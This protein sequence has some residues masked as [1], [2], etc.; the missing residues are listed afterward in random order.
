MTAKRWPLLVLAIVLMLPI[1]T[2]CSPTTREDRPTTDT[3]TCLRTIAPA[4]GT[5]TGIFVEPDDTRAPI[6]NELDHARC[7]I[8]VAVYLLT[9]AEVIAALEAAASRG[10]RV[11]LILEHYPYGGGG[12]QDDLADRLRSEGIDVQWSDNQFRFTHAKYIVVDRQVALILNQNLT[13]SSFT[14]NREFGAVTTDPEAVMGAQLIFDRDWER[15]RQPVAAPPLI[16]SPSDSR[17]RYEKIIGEARVSIDLYAEVIQDPEIIEA[18]EDAV[19]RGVRVRLIL[20]PS[21]GA[22]DIA[23]VAGLRSRGVD[24]RA[25]TRLYIHAKLMIVDGTTAIVG[26]QNFT[27]TSLDANREL[28]LIVQDPLAVAR[29]REIFTTDWDAARQGQVRNASRDSMIAFR[30]LV[31]SE[32]AA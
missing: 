6:L 13:K 15:N 16:V 12:G 19:T 24:V 23:T 2:A 1:L 10:V 22:E 4:P 14:G 9:D 20:N 11:R 17:A 27:R 8:D 30:S 31:I 3:A 32:H 25:A 21:S 18:L 26:S 29:C 5:V 28:A 7:T